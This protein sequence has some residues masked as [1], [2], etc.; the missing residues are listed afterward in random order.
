MNLGK[1][2]RP[3]ADVIAFFADSNVEVGLLVP[4]ETGLGKSIM[5]AHAGLRDYLTLRHVH[6]YETQ[7]Q[8]RDGK[9]VLPAWFVRPRELQASKASLYRPLTKTGDPRIWFS[10]LGSY[11]Q[12]GNVLAIIAHD[13][14]LYVVNASDLAV[15]SSGSIATSP[16]GTLLAQLVPRL[17]PVAQELLAE[18]RRIGSRGFIPS[19][20]KGPTGIGYTLETML[21]IRAN[22]NRAPDYKG[23]EIKAGR[24]TASGRSTSRCNLFSR[25]PN[26]KSSAY[27][28]LRLLKTYG[29]PNAQGRVQI[30]CT[31]GNVPN[32]TFHL[33]LKTDRELDVLDTLR[34]RARDSSTSSVEKIFRWE[35]S[36]LRDA[37]AKKHPETF[38]VKA[39]TQ[40]RGS[41]EQFHYFEVEHTH[42]PLVAHFAPLI[43]SG[44]VELDLLL[45]VES[46]SR[47]KE[48]ARDHGYLFKIWD[49]DRHLLF[50]KP[51]T[52]S[53]IA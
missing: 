11:A 18:L 12:P 19:L 2:D 44:H 36:R 39:R 21:G 28:A 6:D 52:H 27:S 33:Y 43:D 46:T 37:F 7:Q 32:A 13:N 50:G 35:F 53:L 4:T 10:G 9:K 23:I 5:D 38:W 30:Y 34:N 15:M 45:N 49:H 22:A 24:V 51:L 14:A 47:G 41:A 31:L 20:R 48:R 17:T 40:G 29:R 8:G 1:A 42:R 25:A 26:W 3:I 16:L